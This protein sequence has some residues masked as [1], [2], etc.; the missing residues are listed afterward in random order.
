MTQKLRDYKNSIVIG[1]D[2]NGANIEINADEFK[3]SVKQQLELL[4]N[5]ETRFKKIEE[6]ISAEC[7]K[8]KKPLP[9]WVYWVWL[10][11]IVALGLSITSIFWGAGVKEG[12]PWGV[13]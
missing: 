3:A 8:N 6:K 2:A 5:E 10:M 7:A 1:R 9:K 11:S 12:V 13:G 4:L